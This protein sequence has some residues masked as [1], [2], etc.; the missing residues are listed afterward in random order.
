MK[1][2]NQI[3]DF[4]FI[5]PFLLYNTLVAGKYTCIDIL[6]DH[7]I[8]PDI[9]TSTAILAHNNERA[10]SR[11]LQVEL[12]NTQRERDDHR[13]TAHRLLQRYNTDTER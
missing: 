9:I 11:R 2:K 6:L 10:E 1:Y 3:L 7:G 13:R 12:V 5:A 4:D 8:L